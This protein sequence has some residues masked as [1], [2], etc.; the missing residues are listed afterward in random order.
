MHS[1]ETEIQAILYVLITGIFLFQFSSVAHLRPHKLEHVRLPCPSP[2]PRAS[3]T[4]VLPG[5][6]AIQAFIIHRP[7]LFLPSILLSIKVFSNK[8]VRIRWPKY[9]SFIFSISPSNEY[10]GLISFRID[11]F[12]L[13]VQEKVQGKSK[14]FLQLYPKNP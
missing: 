11:W 2:T 5:G 13:V 1:C 3:Q 4:H 10:S 6:N 9:W 8:S 7:L 14:L 12:N